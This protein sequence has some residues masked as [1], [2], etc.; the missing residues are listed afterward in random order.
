VPLEVK[1]KQAAV[2]KADR[3]LGRHTCGARP[4]PLTTEVYYP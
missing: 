3:I 4:I 1:K 2:E